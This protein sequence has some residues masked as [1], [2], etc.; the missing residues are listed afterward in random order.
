MSHHSSISSLS[1][2]KYSLFHDSHG[3]SS[4]KLLLALHRRLA[5]QSYFLA[6]FILSSHPQI[7][8]CHESTLSSQLNSISSILWSSLEYQ[9]W[10]QSNFDTNNPWSIRSHNFNIFIQWKSLMCETNWYLSKHASFVISTYL[11]I[12][13]F[14]R[15]FL[16]SILICISFESNTIINLGLSTCI[17]SHQLH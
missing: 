5:S 11:S 14:V 7:T 16:D 15:Q 10:D 12:L 6:T 8:P 2:C 1:Q 3:T 9:S 13:H 4:S 17:W